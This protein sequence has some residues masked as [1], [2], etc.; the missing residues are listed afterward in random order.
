MI[1]KRD[2]DDH[3]VGLPREHCASVVIN[4]TCIHSNNW[5]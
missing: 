1:T 2:H 4:V 5:K 3:N